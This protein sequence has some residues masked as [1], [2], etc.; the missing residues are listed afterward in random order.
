VPARDLAA[1]GLTPADLLDPAA[2][3][4]AQPLYRALLARALGH[5]DAA[6]RYT[7]AIPRGEWR[8]RLACTWPLMI[9]LETIRALAAH[10]DALAASPPVKIPRRMVRAIV[11]R[12]LLTVWSNRALAA[13]AARRR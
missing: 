8:M 13:D 11:G 4:R 3:P 9:G 7:L 10:P 2:S 1:L 5:Y 6:W 12:S